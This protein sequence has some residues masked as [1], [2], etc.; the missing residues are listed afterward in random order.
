MSAENMAKYLYQSVWAAL[1]LVAGCQ[2]GPPYEPPVTIVPEEWKN[3]EATPPAAPNVCYWWE[4]FHDCQ[5]NELE[6][7]AI[8]NNY[9]LYAAF[10]RVIQ[11]RAMAGVVASALY[12][13]LTVG[14]S[15]D[16][17]AIL[18]KIFIAKPPIPPVLR[19]HQITNLLPLNLSYELDLWGELLSSYQSAAA[20][21]DAQ[22][23]LFNTL[24]LVLTTD[25][26][27]SYFRLKTIDREIDLYISTI[28]TRK[29]AVEI[30]QA[31]YEGRLVN[32]SDVSRA[33][34]D[35]SNVE[36]DYY[37]ARRLREVEINRIA[38]LIGTAAS[39]FGLAH[40][41]LDG[42]PPSVPASMPSTVVQ[43]RPDIAQAERERASQHA[44]V[45]VAYANFFPTITL[46]GTLGYS[47]PDLQHFLKWK[48]RLWS[49]GASALQTAF[50]GGR[51]DYNL[52]AAWAQFYAAD[53]EYKQQVLQAFEEVEDALSDIQM[54]IKESEYLF[55]SVRAAKTTAQIAQDR[56]F[57][58][59]TFYLDVMDSQRDELNSERDYISLQGRRYA[60]T[61]QLV[62]AIGGTWE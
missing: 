51:T 28:K 9:D 17:Q 32:Y 49:L 23:E 38:V 18:Q 11:A 35:L 44:L 26:A 2:V 30:T 15:Y 1:I 5:L 56:Y 21:A 46:T 50:D 6:E 62:K 61:I 48:S 43:Q 54:L 31:R 12:P 45:R 16:N 39:D 7:Q 19:E 8:A 14:P 42:D 20:Y 55:E 10:Q 59:V 13:Q 36:A 4:I 24:L 47:S 53:A 27:T 37:E 40:S 33:K 58:G 22:A 34:L 29:T 60:A 57:Q 25:L 3:E 52:M 41:P